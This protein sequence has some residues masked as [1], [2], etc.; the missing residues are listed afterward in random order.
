MRSLLFSLLIAV[1]SPAAAEAPDWRDS[2]EYDVL[3]S[4]FEIQPRV[5]EL[6]ADEPVRLRFINNSTS[7]HSFSAREFFRSGEVR[8]RDRNLVSSGT[9][10]VQPGDEREVII[11]P[12]AGR[13]KARSASLYHRVLG[14]TAR[15]IVK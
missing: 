12:R 1:A 13:Y 4:S 6:K 14:M 11:V 2:R 10:V 15:I 8:P 7:R 5:I 9:I 3:L